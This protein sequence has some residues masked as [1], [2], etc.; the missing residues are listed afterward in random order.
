[1]SPRDGDLNRKDPAMKAYRFQDKN[2][3]IEAL[4]DPEQ[5]SP[6]EWG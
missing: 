2:R 6:R 5:F 4:L 3:E 1:M